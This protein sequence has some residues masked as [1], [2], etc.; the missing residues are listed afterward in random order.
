MRRSICLSR[1]ELS[2]DGNVSDHDGS[3]Y[4]FAKE[5]SF[6]WRAWDRYTVSARQSHL[7]GAYVE[8]A[9]WREFCS[10]TDTSLCSIA[11]S[12]SS[13]TKIEFGTPV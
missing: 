6:L 7:A 11:I 1:P 12:S 2:P 3:N 10:A 8:N 4:F 5:S 13:S 9:T